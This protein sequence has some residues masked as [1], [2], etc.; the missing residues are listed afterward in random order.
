MTRENVEVALECFR[1]FDAADLGPFA[2]LLHPHVRMTAAEGWP[3]QGPFQG[4]D[5][6]I[7]QFERLFGD[8][9]EYS[10]EDVRV[11]RDAGEWVV[12]AWTMR[13]R[14]RGSGLDVAMDVVGALR[15]EDGQVIEAHYRWS[16]EAAFEAAGL[17]P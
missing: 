15:V 17:A 11:V 9:S 10:L 4:R 12:V 5:A 1:R 6:S 13:A 7:R 16:P 3:E 14:G 8:W 2:E